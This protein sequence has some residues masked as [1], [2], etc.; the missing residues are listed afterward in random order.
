M[1]RHCGV[2]AEQARLKVTASL[3][4]N[5]LLLCNERG[6]KC[7]AVMA[8]TGDLPRYSLLGDAAGDPE[9]L[10]VTVL[11]YVQSGGWRPDRRQLIPKI[12][13]QADR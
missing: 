4:A 6:G 13:V 8:H 11:R 2:C 10:S 9:R 3:V 5:L 1:D 7:G 12:A